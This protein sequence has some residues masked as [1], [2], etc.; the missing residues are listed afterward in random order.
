MPRLRCTRKLLSVIGCPQS[1]ETAEA[2]PAPTRLGDWYANLLVIA[3]QRAL[4]FTN[5]ST[6]YSFAVL[7]VRKATLT[8]LTKVFIEHLALNLADD[9][10]PA[11][12]IQGVTG[13]YHHLEIAATA[14]RH[15]VGSMNNVA[16][17]LE[18]YVHDAGGVTGGAVRTINRQLNRMPHK[19]LGWA[20]AVERLQQRLL[21]TSGTDE[22]AP[23]A[24]RTEIQQHRFLVRLGVAEQ[25]C[26]LLRD[27]QF[28]G[29]WKE[30]LRW[31]RLHGSATQ[32]AEDI[33]RI[34]RLMAYEQKHGVKLRDTLTAKLRVVKW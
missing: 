15:V 2:R 30:M 33:P 6:L 16:A 1:A 31:I 22:S 25:A 28:G 4:L 23:A 26:V 34:Q 11:D 14:S 19:P 9:G 29:S 10:I 27:K 7:G 20:Y 17:L 32:R 8:H 18:R 21:G 24:V 5:E 13:E 12:V 3:R